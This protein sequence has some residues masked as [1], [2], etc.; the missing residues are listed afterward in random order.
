MHINKGENNRRR[1]ISKRFQG[2]RTMLSLNYLP[3]PRDQV[4]QILYI[5]RANV[6]S[7]PHFTTT[8]AVPPRIA[9]DLVGVGGGDELVGEPD[10]IASGTFE[11][12]N[13]SILAYGPEKCGME[14]STA[15]AVSVLINANCSTTQ[16]VGW[17][18]TSKS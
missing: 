3:L 1:G 12:E 17:E 11:A 15:C 6:P 7:L 10:I 16:D 13:N 8:P 2:S 4:P 14:F 18:T 5:P 9:A